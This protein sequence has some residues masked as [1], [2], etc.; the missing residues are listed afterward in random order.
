MIFCSKKFKDIQVPSFE[1][2]ANILQRVNQCKYLGHVIT[3]RRGS[4]VVSTPAYHAADRVSNPAR[5][6]RDY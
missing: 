2:N 5:A 4:V 3:E 1:L 6:R